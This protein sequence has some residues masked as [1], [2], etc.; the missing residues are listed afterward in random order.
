[1][2]RRARVCLPG[3][4]LHIVQR[5]HNRRPCF[6]AESDYRYYLHVLGDQARRQ[7]CVIHAYALMTNHVHLLLTPGTADSAA[8]LVKQVGQRYV[9]HVNRSY[10]RGGTLWDGRFKSSLAKDDAYILTCYRYIELNPVRAGIVSHA[11]Q[12]PWSSYLANGEG[13]A[14][15]VVTPHQQ[16]LALGLN[17]VER[18]RVYR[19]LLRVRLDDVALRRIR[20]AVNGNH[21]LRL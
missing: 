16:Y 3:V 2:P 9:Q 4:P 17:Q 10:A 7:D 11:G 13:I 12:Y 18:L 14:D 15:P 20:H 6:F 8:R 21:V 1:M 19:D 5:G